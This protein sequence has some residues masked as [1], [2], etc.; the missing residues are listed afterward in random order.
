LRSVAPPLLLL[1]LAG[2]A[3]STLQGPR[4]LEPGTRTWSLNVEF[5]SDGSTAKGNEMLAVPVP[6]FGVRYGLLDRLDASARIS[7]GAL[8][9][10]IKYEFLRTGLL[11]AA[12]VPMVGLSAI[13]RTSTDNALLAL[14]GFV[15]CPLLVGVNLGPNVT[16]IVGAG[17]AAGRADVFRGGYLEGSVGLAL[18]WGSLTILPEFKMFGWPAGDPFAPTPAFVSVFGIGFENG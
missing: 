15:E 9:F 4:T 12:L 5:L 8:K 3:M 16:L 13:G 7:P 10:G 17:P 2:C 11:E 1:L 18:R 14:G 6:T